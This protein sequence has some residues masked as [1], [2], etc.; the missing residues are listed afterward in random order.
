MTGAGWGPLD[1]ARLVE[2]HRG[3]AVL[4]RGAEWPRFGDATALVAALVAFDAL[5]EDCRARGVIGCRGS[6]SAVHTLSMRISV[7]ERLGPLGWLVRLLSSRAAVSALEEA[8]IAQG[9]VLRL[10]VEEGARFELE[11]VSKGDY[12]ADRMSGLLAAV[13][14]GYLVE[15]L[16]IVEALAQ[17]PR[18]ALGEHAHGARGGAASAG[19]TLA[20][21]MFSMVEEAAQRRDE[22]AIEEAFVRLRAFARDS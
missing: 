21:L 1:G 6:S 13:R 14:S 2:R 19:V 3:S 22:R 10:V 12:P 5:S 20:A 4:E 11:V 7:E 8:A 15:L 18:P 17:V 16:T 9:T